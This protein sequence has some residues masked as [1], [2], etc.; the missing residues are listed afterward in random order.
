MKPVYYRKNGERL[1]FDF[2][3]SFW[4]RWRIR[5]EEDLIDHVLEE[6]QESLGLDVADGKEDTA[7]LRKWD[8][9]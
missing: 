3:L 2:F 9:M 5:M 6:T 4:E 7:A 8:V 1:N